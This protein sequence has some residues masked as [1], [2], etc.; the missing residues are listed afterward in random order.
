TCYLCRDHPCQCRLLMTVSPNDR[1]LPVKEAAA[2]GREGEK[3]PEVAQLPTI[4]ALGCA[5]RQARCDNC[6]RGE[7]D[8][9]C[10]ANAFFLVSPAASPPTRVRTWCGACASAARKCRW[11]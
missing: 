5:L 1:G 2:T 3:A 4:R 9:P 6:L 8:F 10:K 7:A 11:S